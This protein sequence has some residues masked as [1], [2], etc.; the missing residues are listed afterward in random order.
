M[1]CPECGKKTSG[2]LDKCPFCG[3]DTSSQSKNKSG[4]V[5]GLLTKKK[6]DAPK[7]IEV[8]AIDENKGESGRAAV[9]RLMNPKVI[10][11]AAGVVVIAVI[12]LLIVLTFH[13]K[14]GERYAE[15]A[16]GYIGRSVADLNANSDIFYADGS[17][18]A[19]VNAALRFDYIA[20]DDSS[21]R[22]GGV[23]YPKWAVT[24]NNEDTGGI[25]KEITYTDFT[26]LKNDM[27]GLKT[28]GLISLDRFSEGEKKSKVLREIDIRPYSMTYSRTG[29]IL[30]TYKYRYKLENG[31]EQAAI[32][33]VGFSEK[34][35]YKYSSTELLIPQYM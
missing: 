29:I 4:G 7:V 33:R 19:G 24:V 28:D 11:I 12:V 27:R 15:K 22:A 9:R 16:Y 8:K 14:E 35:D 6:D 23:K 2:K 13:S 25:I 34:G 17:A 21:I 26:V 20:E 30:Y 32:L 10:L 1:K 3:A 31:D 5:F 18:Y